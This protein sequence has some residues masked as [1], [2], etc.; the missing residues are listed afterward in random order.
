MASDNKTEYLKTMLSRYLTVK[1]GIDIR[2][3]F[4]CLNPSHDDQH[5]SMSYY[6]KGNLVKCFS[7]GATYDLFNLIGIDYGL[8]EFK[9]QKAQAE[10]LYPTGIIDK[11]LFANQAYPTTN[12][13]NKSKAEAAMQSTNDNTASTTPAI[14]PE[15]FHQHIH[16]T[17]YFQDRGISQEVIDRFK[18]G[19]D[20]STKQVIMPVKGEFYIRRSTDPKAQNKDRYRLPAGIKKELFNA[21]ALSQKKPVFITEG[22]ID[23]LSIITAGHEALAL[24]AATD[25]NLLKDEIQKRIEAQSLPELILCLDNDEAGQKAAHELSEYLNK[26]KLPHSAA[27]IPKEYKDANG[28]LKASKLA[29]KGFLS[30]AIEG[31]DNTSLSF[32]VLSI[33]NANNLDFYIPTGFDKLDSSL[34]RGLYEGLIVLGA[35]PSLGKTTFA[36]QMALQMAEAGNHVYFYSLEQSARELTIKLLSNKM[37]RPIA[38]IRRIAW[39]FCK[40]QHISEQD[41]NDFVEASDRLHKLNNLHI[42]ERCRSAEAIAKDVQRRYYRTGKQ[43]MII[44]DYL[45]ILETPGARLTDKQAVD[46]NITALKRL[47]AEF[48]VPVMA[49]SNLNREN[50]DKDITMKAFKESGGIEYSTDV[51][52][53]M[54][55]TAMQENKDNI[56]LDKLKEAN[57]RKVQIKILKNRNGISGKWINFDYNAEINQFKPIDSIE[58]V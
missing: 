19:Y 50:Y 16:Q 12:T 40:D 3:P 6:D 13:K 41:Y 5:P 26:N 21:E 52:L 36:L 18:L 9:A 1:H 53:G 49:I 14:D 57:P 55:F 37:S 43:A 34:D 4:K 28:Y 33:Q 10:A 44:I 7:C 47:S 11:P 35:I 17:T 29:F 2:K 45:Q 54:Q 58:I 15:S 31:E 39:S 22:I 56:E 23:A 30:N 27:I 20:P 48:H 25:T 24:P 46:Q 38:D 42:I 8:H 32:H 51:L